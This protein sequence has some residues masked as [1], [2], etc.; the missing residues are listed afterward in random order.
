M[1]V[2]KPLTNEMW[3]ARQGHAPRRSESLQEQL[4]ETLH[5]VNSFDK[6]LDQALGTVARHDQNLA[7]EVQQARGMLERAMEV[8][9]RLNQL[10][11]KIRL[12]EK[13]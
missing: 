1:D 10:Y 11:R 4:H 2:R 3:G 9:R 12:P 8:Q 6:D 13:S 7:E 5:S